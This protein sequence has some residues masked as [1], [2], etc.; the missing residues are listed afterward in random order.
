M[1]PIQRERDNT[2]CSRHGTSDTVGPEGPL[3]GPKAKKKK[4]LITRN[5]TNAPRL[6]KTNAP[7]L[8]KTNTPRL[9]KTNTPTYQVNLTL[10]VG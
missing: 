2:K 1:R 5:K 7:R 4:G 3:D 6:N 9:N 8:N 10:D